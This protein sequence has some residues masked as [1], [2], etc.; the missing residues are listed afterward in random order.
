MPNPSRSE[1]ARSQLPSAVD[2]AAR[3]RHHRTRHHSGRPTR[4]A[5]PAGL[6]TAPQSMVGR[7]ELHPRR[8]RFPGASL[9][10]T[11]EQVGRGDLERG[12]DVEEP[13]VQEASASMFHVHQHVA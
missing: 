4:V 6:M 11:V 8:T 2:S 10:D 5:G 13:F 9:G 7:F 1:Q 3:D 12:G